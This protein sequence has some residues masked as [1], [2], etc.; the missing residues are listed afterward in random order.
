M[1]LY[2][3]PNDKIV[4]WIA[5]YTADENTQLVVKKI[6]SLS[7]NAKKFAE[8]IGVD[9]T[10]VKTL[11]VSKSSRYLYNR[12]FFTEH[13]FDVLPQGCSSIGEHQNMWEM[14]QK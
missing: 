12:V 5:G 9:Y 14:L 8:K 3:S 13:P 2:Y 6:D 11:L 10:A 1:N 4:F 7:D